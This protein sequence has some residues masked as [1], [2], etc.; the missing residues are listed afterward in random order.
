M[1]MHS[2]KA[3]RGYSCLIEHLA[4]HLISRTDRPRTMPWSPYIFPDVLR[5]TSGISASFEYEVMKTM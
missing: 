2:R 3:L 1:C 4:E 5:T